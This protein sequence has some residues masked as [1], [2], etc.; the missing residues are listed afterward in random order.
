MEAKDLGAVEGFEDVSGRILEA[1]ESQPEEQL[2]LQLP[3]IADVV[4]HTEP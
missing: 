4:V 2:R 3:D 1:F